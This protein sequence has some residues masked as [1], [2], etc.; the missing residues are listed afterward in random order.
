[1][2]LTVK[3]ELLKLFTL[4]AGGL[5]LALR[6][7]LY[8]TAMDEKGLLVPGHW[9]EAALWVLT[10]LVVAGMFLLTRSIP[11]PKQGQFARPASFPAALGAIAAASAM[12]LSAFGGSSPVL[13]LAAAAALLIIAFCRMTGKKSHFLCHAVLC[14]F[15]AMRMVGQYQ[16]W[17][18]DPQIADYVFYLSAYVTLMVSAY[19]QAAFD[20]EMGSHRNLWC[21][22]LIA[23]YLCIVSLKDGVDTLL[24][25][26]AAIWALTNLTSLNVPVRRQ[27]PT[28]N[29]EEE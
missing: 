19:Q 11:G 8:T 5:G 23:V 4:A 9:A 28:L 14:A 26:G 3:P 7:V 12:I 27:R 21:L 22:S 20:T 17:N 16:Q 24:L 29:L 2:K 10:A 18:S 15:F 13:S 25:L 1:M 6:T